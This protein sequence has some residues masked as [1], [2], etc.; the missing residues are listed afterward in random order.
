MQS[1]IWTGPRA[2]RWTGSRD[3]TTRRS[4]PRTRSSAP[5][6]GLVVSI[7]KRYVG[8]AGDFFELVSDGNMSLIRAV[9]KFDFS[10]GNRFSTYASWAI[11]KNFARAISAVFRHRDRFRTSHSEMFSTTE[12]P[13]ADQYEQESAQI[14][15]E[16]HVERILDRLDER[17]RQI[18]TSR[19]GLTRGQ[20][21]L[22]LK[23]IGAAMGVTKERIRQIQCRAMSKLRKA[24]KEDRIEYPRARRRVKQPA[25]MRREHVKFSCLP[26]FEP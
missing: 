14:L 23:Q 1:S 12:D 7:A 16:S 18:V 4:R 17:E 25:G 11:M 9:E 3:C 24:A 5:T 15:R 19:F 13:R 21:P 22:T 20:E 6:F 8:P 26:R 10:R 2:D